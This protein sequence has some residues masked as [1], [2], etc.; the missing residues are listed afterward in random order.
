MEVVILQVIVS[1]G[2]VVGSVVLFA[3]SVKG[4]DYEHAD[5][6]ALMPLESDEARPEP[7]ASD[8]EHRP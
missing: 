3:L 2:L 5:R 7:A 6:L 1:L 4:R 8:K